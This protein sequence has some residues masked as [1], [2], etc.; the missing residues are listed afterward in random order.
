M[1]RDTIREAEPKA[2]IFPITRGLVVMLGMT[3]I[4]T[5]SL[6]LTNQG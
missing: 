2:Q 6:L 3:A 4:G 1:I 5:C